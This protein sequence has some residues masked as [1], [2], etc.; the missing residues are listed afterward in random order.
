[1]VIKLII[2]L[3]LT[4]LA[5]WLYHTGGDK[6]RQLWRC[7]C[8]PIVQLLAMMLL[9]AGYLGMWQFW[10]AS[11]I[12]SAL[13]AGALS[14]YWK[15]KGADALWWNWLLTGFGYAVSAFPYI[16]VCVHWYAW[17]SRCI[18]LSLAVMIWSVLVSRVSPEEGG[19]GGLTIL[20]D[21]LLLI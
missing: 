13:L 10:V 21:L 3:G 19:R 7:T 2:L 1:M 20:S 11:L 9:F 14:T 18:V 17:L 4:Y 16:F 15:K 12:S 8:V 6:N 5:G